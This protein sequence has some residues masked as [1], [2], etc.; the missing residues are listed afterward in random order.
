MSNSELIREAKL[1]L[2]NELGLTEIEAFKFIQDTA[3]I[4][5]VSNEEIALRILKLESLR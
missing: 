5:R 3:K 1:R 2:I 4:Q